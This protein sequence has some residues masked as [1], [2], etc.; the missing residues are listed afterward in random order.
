MDSCS[1]TD[2]TVEGAGYVEGNGDILIRI[3]NTVDIT[4]GN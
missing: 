2:N 4:D 1:W 3:H